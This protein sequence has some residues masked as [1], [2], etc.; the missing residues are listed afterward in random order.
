MHSQVSA[1]T[2]HNIIMC[3]FFLL[4]SNNDLLFYVTNSDLN[5]NGW[6]ND[7]WQTD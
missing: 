4:I 1:K 6:A 3:D 2:N 5:T 7:I